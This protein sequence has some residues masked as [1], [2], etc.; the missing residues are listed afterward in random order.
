M[1]VYD[2]FVRGKKAVQ[3]MCFERTKNYCHQFIVGLLSLSVDHLIILG[4]CLFF[5]TS[6]PLQPS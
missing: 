2:M 6:K 1:F 4:I 3:Q 5:I